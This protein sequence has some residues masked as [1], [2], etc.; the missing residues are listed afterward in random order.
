MAI[1]NKKDR[2]AT[3]AARRAGKIHAPSFI[4]YA[5]HVYLTGED[6]SELR[7]RLFA[8]QKRCQIC[9]DPLADGEGEMDHKAGGTPVARCDCYFRRLA[10]GR[11]HTNVQRVCG[12]FSQNNCHNKKHHRDLRWTKRVPAK[13][14]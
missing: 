1:E 9:K 14:Q 10:D 6:R 5:G 11:V 7:A 3:K 13:I 8:K 2:A 4:S 12:R